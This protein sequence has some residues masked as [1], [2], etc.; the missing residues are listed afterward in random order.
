MFVLINYVSIIIGQNNLLCD[1][2]LPFKLQITMAA[3]S[4][5]IECFHIIKILQ[6]GTE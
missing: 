2:I 6:I 4:L 3:M 5:N 1:C